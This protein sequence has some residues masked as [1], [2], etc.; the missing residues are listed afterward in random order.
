MKERDRGKGRK[1][2]DAHE[3]KKERKKER[4]TKIAIYITR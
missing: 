2:R 3:R 1:K 4:K